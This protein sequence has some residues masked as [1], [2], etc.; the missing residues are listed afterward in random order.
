MFGKSKIATS[1]A[2]I[3]SAASVP[4]STPAFAENTHLGWNGFATSYR[5]GDGAGAQMNLYHGRN[6]I[7]GEHPRQQVTPQSWIDDPASPRG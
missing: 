5:N 1:F 7:R 6:A 2:V 3:L 4:P